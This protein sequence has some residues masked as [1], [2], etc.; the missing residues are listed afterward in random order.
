MR[1]GDDQ[2]IHTVEQVFYG[3]PNGSFELPFDARVR[4]QTLAVGL[5]AVLVPVGFHVVYTALS[6]APF[7]AQAGAAITGGAGSGVLVAVFLTRAYAR[8]DKPHTRVDYWAAQAWSLAT[9]PKTPPPPVEHHV[10]LRDATTY[11]A[12]GTHWAV[13]TP[14]ALSDAD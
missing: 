4:S 13:D 14:P 6:F 1:V 3:D 11:L 7:Y 10:A 2:S 5:M 9:A 12:S 8:H